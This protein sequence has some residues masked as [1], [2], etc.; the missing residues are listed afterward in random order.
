MGL[1]QLFINFGE[2]GP[3]WV[4]LGATITISVKI[5]GIGLIIFA[6]KFLKIIAVRFVVKNVING[7][8]L[9]KIDHF[10]VE[11]VQIGSFLG[12]K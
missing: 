9:V 4:I 8:N 2:N 10:L 12:T 5:W 6:Y 1:A 11:M 3:N 7:G